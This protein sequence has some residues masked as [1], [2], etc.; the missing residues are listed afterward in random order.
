MLYRQVTFYIKARAFGAVLIVTVGFPPISQAAEDLS[1]SI[2]E[3]QWIM[4]AIPAG[5]YQMGCNHMDPDCQLIE[6][7]NAMAGMR[8]MQVSVSAFYLAE[9][10]T[11]WNL[12]QLCIDSDQCPG[13]D[14][15]GGDNGWGK[16]DRPVIEISW[17]DINAHFLP[18]IR[19]QTGRT[20]R[21]PT[22]IEWE[23][24]ARAGSTS[25]YPWG[26]QINCS[27]ARYGYSS[28]ECGGIAMTVPVKTYPP[29]AFGLYDMLGNVWEFVADCWSEQVSINPKDP[30]GCEEFTLRGGSWLNTAEELRVSFRAHHHRSYRESGDG[31]RLAPDF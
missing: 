10:E 15:E 16:G 11:T 22:E 29:N 3:V 4:K 21:L 28:D 6:W 30:D 26:D 17:D 7:T 25:R 23:Y 31:F 20:Y 8:Q 5:T 1:E 14:K 13:N 24:A 12:Y 27:Q 19:R 9:T 18:W 2:D